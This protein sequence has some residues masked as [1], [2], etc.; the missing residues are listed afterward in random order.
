MGLSP[1]TT[2]NSSSTKRFVILFSLFL[3]IHRI[4]D[5]DCQLTLSTWQM[6]LPCTMHNART[7]K[8]EKKRAVTIIIGTITKVFPF[9]S[10]SPDTNRTPTSLTHPHLIHTPSLPYI[11]TTQLMPFKHPKNDHKQTITVFDIVLPLILFAI[12]ILAVYLAFSPMDF[13]PVTSSTIDKYPY[14]AIFQAR[15]ADPSAP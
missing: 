13:R 8:F 14:G 11:D 4:M 15:M 3:R 7:L 9:S 5:E 12:L 10:S 1:T 6:V 2:I